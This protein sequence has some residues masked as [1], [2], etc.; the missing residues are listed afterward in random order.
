MRFPEPPKNQK[1]AAPGINKDIYEDSNQ[2]QRHE[3][4][5]CVTHS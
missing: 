4:F 5:E 1:W 3:L 2:P